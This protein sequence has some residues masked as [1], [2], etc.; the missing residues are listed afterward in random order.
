LTVER[1]GVLRHELRALP[2]VNNIVSIPVTPDFE[3]NARVAVQAVTGRL[4]LV[5]TREDGSRRPRA[6]EASYEI[7]VKRDNGL[8][9]SM[10]PRPVPPRDTREPFHPGDDV[11]VEVRVLDAR[12]APARAQ[13]TLFAVDEGVNLL[14][15]YRLPDPAVFW[16]SRGSSVHTTDTRESLYWEPLHSFPVRAPTIR[17]GSTSVGDYHPIGRK[18][19]VPV[20][21]FRPD[22]VVDADGRATVR[23]ALPHNT[24]TWKLYAVAANDTIGFGVAE[25]QIVV[26]QAFLVRPGL[27]RF[28]R[29]GDRMVGSAVVDTTRDAPADLEVSFSASDSATGQGHVALS[30]PA[31]GHRAVRFEVQANHPGRSKMRFVLRHGGPTVDDIELQVPVLAPWELET[32]AFSGQTRGIA[33]ERLALENRRPDTGSLEY[34]VAGTPLVGLSEGFA[35]LVEYPYGCTEQLVSRLV[36]LVMLRGLASAYG[37]SLPAD[38]RLRAG[39]AIDG[40]LSH[41]KSSGGFGSWST[42]AEASPW[43]TTYAAWGLS[44]AKQ[45][46]Y[47]VPDAAIDKAF[48][49]LDAE[50]DVEPAAMEDLAF[51]EDVRASLGRPRAERLRELAGRTAL[52]TE[53][54]ALLAHALARLDP[55]S[56]RSLL[57]A[58]PLLAS[59][60]LATVAPEDMRG[61]FPSSS[62]RA[63]ALVLR[64]FAAIDPKSARVPALTRGL[65]SLRERGRW[66]STQDTAWAL[67]A[68]GD[69][70]E[71]GDAAPRDIVVRLGEEKVGDAHLPGASLGAH[72]G[73]LAMPRIAG[74]STLSF[75]STSGSLVYYEAYLRT[76]PKDPAELPFSHGLQVDKTY[77]LMSGSGGAA[78]HFHV[79]D[80]VRVDIYVTSPAPRDQVVLDDPLPAGFE[81]VTGMFATEV[82]APTLPESRFDHREFRDDRVLTF[83]DRM[84][85]DTL[86]FAYRARVTTAGAFHTPPARAECM[87]VPDLFGRTE[88]SVVDVGP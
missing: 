14:A 57:D 27:P 26:S 6:S 79:G 34:R 43:L 1:E 77:R 65:L 3:P 40:I 18:D 52:P 12:G 11:D 63:T 7:S 36:P 71:Q 51:A 85:A 54:R 44:V 5:P 76:A 13:V 39:E 23:F 66:A 10:T 50:K 67:L 73:F 60:A 25:G 21:V 32:V 47:V 61:P 74:K 38:T 16:E 15:P 53:A 64:A 86:H 9:L 17:E 22:I 33:T 8:F 20:A 84:P 80:Y 41:Q 37:L 78:S 87:Y 24:T 29:V 35:Q 31:L 4:G 58:I 75:E 68:L 59:G 56:A 30:L 69:V 55:T 2:L 81:P 48:E 62:A 45:A 82:G 42:S 70:S 72:A 88:A 83:I 46:G 28:L 49:S 19:F